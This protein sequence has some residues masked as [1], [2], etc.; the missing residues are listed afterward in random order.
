LMLPY[1][2]LLGLFSRF[3][4]SLVEESRWGYLPAM[5][6]G[7]WFGARVD[8][9][10]VMDVIGGGSMVLVF[11]VA[12]FGLNRIFSVTNQASVATLVPPRTPRSR[13]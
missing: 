4:L 6:A 13:L 7:I 8:G 3:S 2:I 11:Y 9:H 1:G 10:Y 12:V 5:L